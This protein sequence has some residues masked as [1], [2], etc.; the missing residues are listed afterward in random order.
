MSDGHNGPYGPNGPSGPSVPV[1]PGPGTYIPTWDIWANFEI[2]PSLEWMGQKVH[3]G[4]NVPCWGTGADW[5]SGLRKISDGHN[6]PYGPN[7]PSGP[8]VP[9][10]PGPGTYIPTRDIW[11]KFQKLAQ[12]SLVGMY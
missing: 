4:P 12:M 8:S 3:F 1:S 2:W 9:V 6:G 5:T 7:G 11:A 10:S